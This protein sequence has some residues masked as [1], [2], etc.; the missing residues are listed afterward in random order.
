MSEQFDEIFDDED[1]N[2]NDLP[3]K[4]RQ[5]IKALQKERDEFAQELNSLRTE[6]RKRSL[7][8][9]LQDKG[10]SP[11][12]AAFVP[13]DVEGEA[14]DTWLSEFGDVF[15][16]PAVSEGSTT[17][18]EPVIARDAAEAAAI[19]QMSAA[20]KGSEAPASMDLLAQIEQSENMQELLNVLGRK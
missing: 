14:L 20:E 6:A 3:K 12:I 10:L 5:Q 11:K 8:E 16:Q 1:S 19:R 2:G 13:A 17:E 15:G 4:L 7:A 9:T 18:S